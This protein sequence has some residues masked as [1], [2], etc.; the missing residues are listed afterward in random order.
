MILVV[1]A[2]PSVDKWVWVDRFKTGRVNRARRVDRFPGGKGV[3]VALAASE[4][5]EPVI[6]LG[7][8]AGP[9]GRWVREEVTARGVRRILGPETEGWTRSCLTL[10]GAGAETELLEPG[11]TVD[12]GA[13]SQFE[14]AFREALPDAD[15]VVLSGSL[16]PRL[17]D[18]TYERFI[19]ATRASG[20]PTILDS[21]G[22]A[23]SAGLDAGPTWAKGNR[24]EV[25]GALGMEVRSEALLEQ[26]C[27]KADSAVVT[28]GPDGALFAAGDE[29]LKAKGQVEEVV[30]AVGS[31]DCMTAGMAVAMRRG[32]NLPDLAR[33]ATACALANCVHPELGILRKRDVDAMLSQVHIREL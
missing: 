3:H 7:I 14:T 2:N 8:W 17:D 9:A 4:L 5:G 11:P 15:V 32:L 6:L 26:L 22:Q 28:L 31:G 12:A 18:G 23:F 24:D 13:A 29:R 1:C 10:L 30:S 19:R 27:R 25:A 33:L 21:S 16:P 20:I